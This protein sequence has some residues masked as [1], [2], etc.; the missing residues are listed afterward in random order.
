MVCPV[1]PQA[2]TIRS[3]GLELTNPLPSNLRW[4]V[5]ACAFWQLEVLR[6]GR[7]P[8]VGSSRLTIRL[9]VSAGEALKGLR[10]YSA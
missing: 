4:S 9:K 6:E 2:A 3:K 5:I 7:S 1:C 8:S 10:T